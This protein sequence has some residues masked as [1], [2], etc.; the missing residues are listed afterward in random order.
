MFT[1]HSLLL[2]IVCQ[3]VLETII[4]LLFWLREDLRVSERDPKFGDT[5]YVTI[6]DTPD[7]PTLNSSDNLKKSLSLSTVVFSNIYQTDKFLFRPQG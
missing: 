6:F 3:T 1:K 2:G 7:R 4:V 5:D